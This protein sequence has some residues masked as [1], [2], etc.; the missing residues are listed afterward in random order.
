MHFIAGEL[1]RIE[2]SIDI[3]DF[4]TDGMHLDFIRLL[5][6]IDKRDIIPFLKKNL[7]VLREIDEYEYSDVNPIRSDYA[8]KLK[9]F[10]GAITHAIRNYR[11]NR[12][13]IEK[14]SLRPKGSHVIYRSVGINQNKLKPKS[15]KDLDY[16]RRSVGGKVSFY[17]ADRA[18]LT[19]ELI[20]F[21]CEIAGSKV[22]KQ[23]RGAIKKAKRTK[24]NKK[25]HM[26]PSH[27]KRRRRRAK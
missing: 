17:D 13:D 18:R 2:D 25:K 19:W 4:N 10:S 11:L 27:L 7:D 22:G 5:Q 15:S 23:A 26:S 21:L 6:R 9:V 12:L 24:C 3:H 14:D 1:Q 8:Q 20:D 16:M